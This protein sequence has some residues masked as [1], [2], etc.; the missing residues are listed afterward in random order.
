MPALLGSETTSFSLDNMGRF[1]CNTLQEAVDGAA[2]TVGDQR[3]DF[4]VIVV[5][6]GSFGSVVANGLFMK[7]KTRSRRILVL[8]Q[9]PFVLPEHV[10]NLPWMGG[11]PGYRV[12]WVTRPGSDLNYAG[13]LYG[14]G[15]RSLT[16][17]GWSPEMLHDQNNDEMAGWPASVINDLQSKYFLDAGDQIGTNSTNDYIFGPLHEAMRGQLFDGL[18]AGAGPNGPFKD[19]KLADLPDAAPVRAFPRRNGNNPPT[20]ADLLAMLGIKPTGLSRPQLLNMMKIEAPLAVQTRAEP[21]QFPIN[22]FSGVP[23]LVEAARSASR[24]ADGV[25]PAADARKR[26]TVVPNCQVLEFVTETQ[27][28]N[29]VRV[30]G[31]SVRDPGGQERIV[32]LAAPR[33]DGSQGVVVVALGT[34]ESTRV[35]LTTFQSSLGWRAAQRMGKNYMAHLRSNLTIRIPRSA[36]A[37]LPAQIDLKALQVS[38]LFVKGKATVS[39]RTRYFHLQITASG[40]GRFGNDSEAELFKKIPSLEHMNALLDADDTTVVITLRGIG[41][42]TP[43]NPDSFVDLAKTPTD[44]ENGRP[45]AFADIGDSR[46]PAGGSA[47]TQA[48]RALW[49]KMDDFTDEVALIF[50]NGQ[51]FEILGAAGGAT[52]QVPAGAAAA[53]LKNLHPH[54]DRRDKLGTTHHDAGTLWMSDDP[55]TGVTNDFGRIHDTTNCYVA[56]PALFPSLGSPNPMLTAVALARRTVD[57][58]TDSVLPKPAAFQPLGSRP[59][60]P[61]AGLI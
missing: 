53:D 55:A 1:L 14:V 22:K 60:W 13:L 3:R 6:G 39:G 38:A 54:K 56:G 21:G 44:W 59:I 47:E 4:D 35:A 9:G 32:P 48:D 46:Q 23:I 26:L 11:D 37:N 2:Q 43:H 30:T 57:L 28:D 41:E 15:G 52:I 10:Q 16:W 49:E 27:P 51:S 25:G 7:D 31:V 24:E 61:L 18:N 42:M 5:G 8:E 29:W 50:A 12:P 33:P 36:L 19:L 58:L 20:G 40:L 34:I 45:R 17:G